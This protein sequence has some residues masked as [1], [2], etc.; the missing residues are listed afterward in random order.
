MRGHHVVAPVARVG[1]DV[2]SE[3]RGEREGAECGGR[4][5]DIDKER[6]RNAVAK[7]PEEDGGEAGGASFVDDAS[8]DGA[9]WVQEVREDVY[10][11][12]KEEGY[13]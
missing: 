3:I 8:A 13:T 12:R 4:G 2:E 11:G 1:L 5:E 6:I 7:E 10:G 9:V